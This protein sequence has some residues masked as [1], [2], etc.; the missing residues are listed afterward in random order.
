MSARAD[1]VERTREQILQAAYALWV[2]REYDE[3]SL[4]AVAERAGMTKQTVIRQF[5]SKERL[6]VAVIDWQRP[7]EEAARAVAP[8]DLSG[9][10]DA[11]LARYEQMGD[12]NVR[13]L[14][15]EQRVPE[16]RY[17]LEQGR[18]SHRRWIERVFAPFLPSKQGAARR[19]QVM[20]FYAATDVTAWKLL[21]RDFQ[22][23][24]RVT[25]AVLLSTISA[26]ASRRGRGT[27]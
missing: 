15:L 22:L 10:L 13:M 1:G 16:L 6:A 11:L 14:S 19:Q 23:S 7:R 2:E 17:L 24:R 9:A 20:A 8:G 4:Q 21:R 18:D 26:L 27:S 5:G 25:A 3:V 12:A